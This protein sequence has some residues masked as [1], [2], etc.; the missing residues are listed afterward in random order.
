MLLPGNE[1]SRSDNTMRKTLFFPTLKKKSLFYFL[2]QE[3]I[4][5]RVLDE[6]ILYEDCNQKQT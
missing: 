6:T 2:L 4:C 1:V 5:K 3:E